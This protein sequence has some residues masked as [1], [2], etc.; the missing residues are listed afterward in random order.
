MLDAK[1]IRSDPDGVRTAL[2]RRGGDATADINRFLVLDGERRELLQQVETARAER[3][4]A[5]KAI[6]DWTVPPVAEDGVAGFLDLLVHSR[7]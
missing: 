3:N 2:E 6:A 5:A 1:L 7:A 4:A